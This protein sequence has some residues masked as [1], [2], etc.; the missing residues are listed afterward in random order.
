MMSLRKIWARRKAAHELRLR[1]DNPLHYHR[2]R[3][4]LVLPLKKSLQRAFGMETDLARM[5]STA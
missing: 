3:D 5:P 2:M 1:V 4:S